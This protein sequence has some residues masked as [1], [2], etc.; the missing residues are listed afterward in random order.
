[1]PIDFYRNGDVADLLSLRFERDAVDHHLLHILT[2]S[3]HTDVC[4]INFVLH[5]GHGDLR[6]FELLIHILFQILSL[7]PNFR[8]D[9]LFSLLNGI[10]R[11]LS[12]FFL[13]KVLGQREIYKLHAV[14]L[15]LLVEWY[16][17]RVFINR[18]SFTIEDLVKLLHKF[19]VVCAV[20]DFI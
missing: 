5:P 20:N 18:L 7:L 9:F 12:N 16:F 15:Y 13:K 3:Y 17:G 1:M 19:L 14:R 11:C 4:I 6:P 8:I 2:L 10:L